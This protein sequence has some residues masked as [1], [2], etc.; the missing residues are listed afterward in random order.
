MASTTANSQALHR[1]E[2]Y[3]QVILDELTEG[4]LPEGLA[5]DVSDFPDGSKLTI[6]TF[7][8]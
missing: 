2:V 3:S 4:F 1:A 6:P 5:R 7:K 8:V